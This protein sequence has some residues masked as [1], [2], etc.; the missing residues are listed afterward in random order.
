MH[1][2]SW[3]CYCTYY[4]DFVDVF[5]K[6]LLIKSFWNQLH[7]VNFNRDARGFSLRKTQLNRL[8]LVFPF[9]N[10]VDSDEIRCS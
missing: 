4:L 7:I 10:E 9:L 8:L 2:Y 6:A 3:L 1:L 5:G